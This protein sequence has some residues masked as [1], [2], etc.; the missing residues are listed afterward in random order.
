MA[1]KLYP[2]KNAPKNTPNLYL[3]I[4][5]NFP[6]LKIYKIVWDEERGIEKNHHMYKYTQF[7][8]RPYML[9]YGCDGTTDSNIHYLAMIICNHYKIDYLKAYKLAYP[10]RDKNDF[11]EWKMYLNE[12]FNDN[13][14]KE[15][16]IVPENII[17]QNVIELIHDLYE[18]NYQSLV[19]VLIEM[20][21]KIN[22]DCD[23]F[24]EKVQKYQH[25]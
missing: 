13:F 17:E 15:T 16:T 2:L 23:F 6:N 14:I 22:I 11:F 4:A 25:K 18:I 10:E 7:S 24:W 5:K 12:V 9:T 21:Q 19:Q 1:R 20:F 3:S 8:V